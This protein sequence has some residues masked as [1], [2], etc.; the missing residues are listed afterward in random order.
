[1]FYLYIPFGEQRFYV[2]DGDASPSNFS[3]TTDRL[4]ARK[5]KGGGFFSGSTFAKTY[6]SRES[7][8]PEYYVK[9]GDTYVTYVFGQY[10]NTAHSSTSAKKFSK[11]DALQVLSSLAEQGFSCLSIQEVK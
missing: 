2:K 4:E 3:L 6:F 9:V 10:S 7:V 8:E 5:F 11:A 1:M